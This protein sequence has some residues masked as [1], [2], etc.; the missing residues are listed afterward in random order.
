MVSSAMISK[1]LLQEYELELLEEVREAS[2][3]TLDWLSREGTLKDVIACEKEL[4]TNWQYKDGFSYVK[5]RL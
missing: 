4:P 2:K 3:N 1:A 5:D